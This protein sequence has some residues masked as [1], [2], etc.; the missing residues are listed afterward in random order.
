MIPYPSIESLDTYLKNYI[1]LIPSNFDLMMAIDQSHL[2]LLETLNTITE[3]KSTY[4]YQPNKWSIKTMVMH[5]TDT[6]RV[7]LYRALAISRGEEVNLPSFD[8]NIYANNSFADEVPYQQLV[9]EYSLI[10]D[11]FRVLFENMKPERALIEGTA[12][13]RKITP[14]MIG[15]LTAGHRF[16]HLNILNE[17]YL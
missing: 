2:A 14:A 3:E 9:I 7:F 11:S 12:N 6:E 15:F 4:R 17:R 16:H 5:L 8:E 10:A 13:N 1:S